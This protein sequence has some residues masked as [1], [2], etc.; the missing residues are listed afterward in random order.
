MMRLRPT[1]AFGVLLALVGTLSAHAPVSPA[2]AKADL[3]PNVLIILTDD[4]RAR[5]TYEMLPKTM[6]IFRSGGTSYTNAFATTPLCCP[7]RA[8]LF[9]GRYAH[10]HGVTDTDRVAALDE[11]TTIQARL[12]EAGYSTAIVGKYRTGGPILNFD[13][14][15]TMW[16]KHEYIGSRFDL[17]GSVHRVLEY[18]TDFIASQ[19]LSYLDELAAQK[20]P[21]YM[22]VSVYA[23]HS[24]AT[25][26][27]RDRGA[28]ISSWIQDPATLET[29]VSDKP[30]VVRR[31]VARIGDKKRLTRRMR[32]RQLRSLLAVD[33]LVGR[34]YSK[35]DAL[36][37]EN[38]LAF[39]LSD[40]GYMWHEHGLRKKGWPYDDSVR[41]PFL[42]R[43][44][45]HIAAGRSDPELVANIDVAPTIYEAVGITPPVEPDGMSLFDP[46][47]RD[48]LVLEYWD[49]RPGRTWSS[50]RSLTYQY[51]EYSNGEKEYY[52]LTNDAWQLQNLFAGGNSNHGVDPN[53]LSER[54][55]EGL[56]CAGAE[57][58]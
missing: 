18:S 34:V 9:T 53:A 19:A 51:I 26:A 58:P 39:F 36:G 15:S 54:L 45:S 42:M 7:S 48:E 33:D 2:A 40:N 56:R 24:P 12:H 5:G 52:D 32:A 35:L 29:D 47:S 23:P 13:L 49:S 50:L 14:W 55:R 46:D 57:C 6:G 37:E 21:W 25:P 44:P 17:N 38:T 20:A 10:N 27:A 1:V 3:R 16:P 30:A 4:Q 28:P 43:W 22:V 11:S 41:V 31:V 8:S